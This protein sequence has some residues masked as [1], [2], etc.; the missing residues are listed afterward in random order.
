MQIELNSI[1][2]R[3]IVYHKTYKGENEKFEQGLAVGA[4]GRF[5]AGA[6]RKRD[7]PGNR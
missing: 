4:I 6:G 5:S 2:D 3:P 1:K 7:T